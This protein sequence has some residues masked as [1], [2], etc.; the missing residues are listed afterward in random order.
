MS[1]PN[2]LGTFRPIPPVILARARDLRHP[3]MPM[4]VALWAR[5]RDSQLAG[6]KFRRQ[7]SI[8]RFIVDFYCAAS[9]LI[10]EVDGESHT[11]QTEYDAARTEWLEACD[12]QVRRFTNDE[13]RLNL[14]GV[15]TTILQACQATA[16]ADRTRPPH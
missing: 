9:Q 2:A 11:T 15:L 3:Q 4:E 5:R 6:Y 16:P 10:I 8:D 7:H 1:N 14:E 12:Y 13:V